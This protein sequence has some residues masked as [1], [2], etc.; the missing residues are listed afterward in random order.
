LAGG[1]ACRQQHGY[2]PGAQELNFVQIDDQAVG[3]MGEALR[4]G[5]AERRGGEEVDL[6]DDP[7]QRDARH[8]QFDLGCYQLLNRRDCRRVGV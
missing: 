5:I 8:R 3:V 1:G 2:P 7:N 6:A 4:D